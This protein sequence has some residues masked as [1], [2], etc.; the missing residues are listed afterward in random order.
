[1][2]KRCVLV[3]VLAVAATVIGWSLQ[4]TQVCAVEGIHYDGSSQ[5]YWALV[6][7]SMEAF[8]KET[9]IKVTA[10][11]RKTQD[12]VPS[13]VSGRCNVGGLARK[14]KLAEKSQS[15]DLTETLIARDHI[16]VFVPAGS[17]A[18]E[19]TKE[20]LRKVFSG[21]ITDWKDLGDD[22][23]PIQVVI[24]QTKTTCNRN[25]TELVMGDAPFAQ[26]SV[27]TETAGA[28]LDAAKGKRAIS[29]I[30]FGAVSK[31]A[32]FKVLKVDGKKP[33]ENGY[34]IAQEMYFATMG[35]PSGDVKKYVDFFL[36]GSGKEIILKQGLLTVQ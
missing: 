2:F 23:G 27:I 18:E 4:A 25:F 12:A 28:V 15:Q 21:Q 33:G 29:F 6:K 11:D 14:M 24:P 20:Q 30:S 34:P 36:T 17:K 5:I 31:T 32:D 8:T 7:D 10:E 9:G 19:V 13:L 16:A 3:G 22:P 35:P 26:S 1:M